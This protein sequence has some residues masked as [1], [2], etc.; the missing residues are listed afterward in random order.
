VTGTSHPGRVVVLA[1]D[2]IWA[3]RL[4][5][6]LRTLGS[7]PVRASSAEV[8]ARELPAAR[9]VVDLTARGYDAI[10]CIT[11]AKAAGARVLAVGQHDDALLRR[12]A[13]EAGADRVF[14]YRALFEH[15]HAALAGWLG[16]EAPAPASIEAPSPVKESSAP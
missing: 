12:A 1:D 13:L 16:V 9:V 3:T 6:Q 8:L 10:A 15:G 4:A 2:L 14:S 7:E 11:A 5:G